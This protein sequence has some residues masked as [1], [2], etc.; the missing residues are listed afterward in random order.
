MFEMELPASLVDDVHKLGAEAARAECVAAALKGVL[1]G[2]GGDRK[3]LMEA[4]L[5]RMEGAK[6]RL[7]VELD[8]KLVQ[9][10]QAFCEHK[11]LRPDVL[12][13]GALVGKLHPA[14]LRPAAAHAQDAAGGAS[15]QAA[16]PPAPAPAPVAEWGFLQRL[17]T[18]SNVLIQTVIALLLVVATGYLA[19]RHYHRFD[20]TWTRD[21]S[22]SDKTHQLLA[23]LKKPVV[24]VTQWMPETQLQVEVI[25][26]VKDLL[27]EYAHGS[28]QVKVKDIPALINPKAA[29]KA[30]QDLGLKQPEKFN[31]VIIACGDRQKTASLDSLYEADYGGGQFG[32][33]G[34]GPQTMKAFKAEE[35]LT[36]SIQNVMQDR[37]PCLYFLQ[38]HKEPSLEDAGGRGEQDGISLLKQKL[39]SGE[40]WDVKAWSSRTERAV[41]DECDC[42]AIV[43]PGQKLLPEEL[44]SVRKYLERGGRL[45]CLLEPSRERDVAGLEVFLRTWGVEVTNGY[46][47]EPSRKAR[48]VV[49]VA[50]G[51]ADARIYQDLLKFVARDYGHHPISEKLGAAPPMF[52]QAC[53]VDKLAS[54]PPELEVTP[55]AKS[56]AES[57]IRTNLSLESDRLVPGEDRAGPISLAVAVEKKLA[58]A[59]D[60]AGQ[61]KARLVVIGNSI[62]VRDW[63]QGRFGASDLVLNSMRWLLEQEHMI[64]IE[65]KKP[66]SHKLSVESNEMENLVWVR[67]VSLF[68]MPL[69]SALFGFAVWFLRRR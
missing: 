26:K 9:E 22:L 8:A 30:F 23:N 47:I 65:A 49:E 11:D 5:P 18:A 52:W 61:R 54:A 33:M 38:G 44:D 31:D 68:G 20:G 48:L 28:A 25:E 15:S 32:M 12:L 62:Q 13:A 51:M 60:G 34:G 14:E 66:E 29:E 39:E 41:P 40:N 37:R 7:S 43:D 36:S 56:T 53:G 57:F 24:I 69:C 19:H 3:S 35:A 1:D 64:S 63:C 17:A 27:E 6:A 21:Y 4:A 2:S 58:G 67:N 10:Y 46:V 45:L 42:L 55:L 59:G 50:P 16:A